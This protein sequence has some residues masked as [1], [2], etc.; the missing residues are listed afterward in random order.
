AVALSAL[1]DQDPDRLLAAALD[2]PE[3]EPQGEAALRRLL[4]QVVPVAVI[5]VDRAYLH[6]VLARIAHDLRRRV[7]A[8]RLAVQQ[9]R[10]EDGRVM[11]FHP[12]RGIGEDGEAGGMAF[13]KAVF[14]ETPDLV[15]AAFGRS[16]E[17]T[18]ELQS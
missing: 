5:D 7:E 14:A 18:S 8:H 9:G 10:G 17:H 2:L 3:A 1:L 11:A 6:I 16:E 4:Q 15:E 13:R 12:G